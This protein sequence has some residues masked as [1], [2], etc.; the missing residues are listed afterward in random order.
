MRLFEKSLNDEIPELIEN[1]IAIEVVGDRSRFPDSLIQAMTH[2]EQATAA[3]TRL[4]LNI[5]AN[6]GGRWDIAD[7][8]KRL[9][10][11]VCDGTLELEAID[12]QLFEDY[13]NLSGQTTVDLLIRTGGERRISNFLLWQSAYA[14]L[15]FSDVLWPDFDGEALDACL[16]GMPVGNGALVKPLNRLP[17]RNAESADPDCIGDASSCINDL[18]CSPGRCLC[19]VCRSNR[20]GWCL[21]MDPF[22]WIGGQIL[23]GVLLVVFSCILIGCYALPTVYIPMLLGIGCLFWIAAAAIVVMYLTE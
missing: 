9:A 12:E 20:L 2:A 10:A 11:R 19:N 22:V 4:K 17:F 7:T 3:G 16:L 5:L 6:Y 14:E 8:A 23:T 21:G 18:I 15:V 1:K 13:Q